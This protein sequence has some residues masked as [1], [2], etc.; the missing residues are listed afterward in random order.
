MNY[1]I[2]RSHSLVTLFFIISL[3]AHALAQAPPTIQFFMP[4]GSLPSRELRFTLESDDG[5]VVDTFFTDSKGRFLIT[6][7]QGLR[8]NTGYRISIRSDGRTFGD[9]TISFRNYRDTV[10]YIPIFLRPLESE[11]TP[12]A[13]VVDLAELD[14]Q[15]PEEAKIAYDNAMSEIKTGRLDEAVREFKRAIEI[16]PKYFRALNDLGVVLMKLDRLD[17]AAQSFERA[18]EIAPRVYYPRLNLAIART[19]QGKYAEAIRL[20]EALYKENPAL[21]QVLV[22]FADALMAVDRLGEADDALRKVLS[23]DKLDSEAEGDARY[24][25]GLLLNRKQKYPEAVRELAEAAKILPGAAQVRLQYGMALKMVGQ[26]TE[27]EREL[28]EAYRL[29]GARMGAA[30]FLLGELYF[31]KKNYESAMR[32]FEQYL[33]DVPAAPNAAEVRS[34]VDRIKAA[35]DKK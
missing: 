25:R 1:A 6:R 20:L 29:G 13:G 24:K 27:A 12:R 23:D 31:K 30:Q 19:R 32:A 7:S 34:V 15:I 2:A 17:E 18:A 26:Q 28:L 9:T 22:A 21:N 10:Y 11:P 4:D 3:S 5:R 35:L 33:I 16:F 14:T 8:A